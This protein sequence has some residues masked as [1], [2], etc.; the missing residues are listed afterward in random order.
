[1]TELLL[2]KTCHLWEII[3]STRSSLNL[4]I[5]GRNF[6]D[7]MNGIVAYGASYFVYNI[8]IDFLLRLIGSLSKTNVSETVRKY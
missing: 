6:C 7:M 5:W 8:P 2:T 1:M 4:Y 3:V